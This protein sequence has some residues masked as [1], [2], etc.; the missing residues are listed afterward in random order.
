[1]VKKIPV[2]TPVK[3]EMSLYRDKRKEWMLRRISKR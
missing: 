3:K 1:M 2:N